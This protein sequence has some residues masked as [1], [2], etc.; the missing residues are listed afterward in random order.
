MYTL[1]LSE[2]DWYGKRTGHTH[3]WSCWYTNAVSRLVVGYGVDKPRV[4]GSKRYQRFANCDH[5]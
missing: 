3:A 4:Y 1:I 5:G 2:R